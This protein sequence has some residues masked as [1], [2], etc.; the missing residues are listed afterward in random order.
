MLK[1][2][3]VIDYW[4]KRAIKLGETAVGYGDQSLDK[5]EGFY[6]E[7][8]QFIFKYIY[9]DRPTIDYGCGVG[10]Y[11]EEFKDDY[12]GVDV[13]E[14]MIKLACRLHPDKEFVLLNNPFLNTNFDDDDDDKSDKTG[15]EIDWIKQFFTATV[16]QHCDNDLVIKILKS[17]HEL[18]PTGFH[19]C[20]YENSMSFEKPHIVGR[21]PEQYLG[22]IMQAGFDIKDAACHKHYVKKEEHSLL[23]AEV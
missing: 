12:L 7:R 6:K 21:K 13:T 2:E 8:K 5:Q 22:M 9:R 23:I 15:V 3:K 18:K 4:K 11:S 10:R 17:V 1:E 16:L 14:E 19:F 20:F